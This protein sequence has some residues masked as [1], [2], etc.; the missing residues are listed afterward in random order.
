VIKFHKKPQF[1]STAH[2]KYT[3]FGSSFDR[4]SRSPMIT[5]RQARSTASTE[6]DFPKSKKFAPNG[7]TRNHKF[8]RRD[9]GPKGGG[10]GD[11]AGQERPLYIDIYRGHVF[12]R[13][14]DDDKNKRPDTVLAIHPSEREEITKLLA[15][16]AA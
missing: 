11:R 7:E 3:K 12:N 16:L 9:P 15:S 8:E 14:Y 5:V 1:E 2:H 10:R 4:S 13:I 6:P